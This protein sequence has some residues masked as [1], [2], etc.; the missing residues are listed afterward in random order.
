M[1]NPTANTAFTRAAPSSCPQLKSIGCLA[2][3]LISIM[4]SVVLTLV[5]NLLLR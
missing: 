1:K 5:V 4:A 3:L 2:M